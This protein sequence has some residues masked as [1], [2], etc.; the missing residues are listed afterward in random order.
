MDQS[1]EKKV[2]LN[3]EEVMI[4]LGLGWTSD[5]PLPVRLFMRSVNS[6]LYNLDLNEIFI[7]DK[8]EENPN[9]K[10][11]QRRGTGFVFDSPDE[12]NAILVDQLN[13]ISEISENNFDNE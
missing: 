13:K 6:G 5:I 10:C 2:T 1:R 12:K 9:S 3:L 4:K 7:Q 8:I 11:K